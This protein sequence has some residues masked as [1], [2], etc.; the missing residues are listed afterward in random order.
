MQCLGTH[1]DLIPGA[2]P[3]PDNGSA[4]SDSGAP[5][6]LTNHPAPDFTLTAYNGPAVKLSSLRGKPVIL[7][8]WATWC[9]PC[10]VEMPWFARARHA[11]S[12]QGLEV[13]GVAEDAPSPDEVQQ[14][15]ARTG[16]D[17]PLLHGTRDVAHA[18]GGIDYLPQTFYIGRDGKVL[19]QTAGLASENEVNA[20]IQKILATQ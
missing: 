20:N 17:Y 6:D 4:A 2:A 3:T 19:A 11:Y 13:L 16:A 8:F 7:N 1:V 9:A 12:A 18:Y 15:V 14:V 5:A 10:K